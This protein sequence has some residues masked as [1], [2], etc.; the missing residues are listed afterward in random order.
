MTATQGSAPPAAPE[1]PALDALVRIPTLEP[2][3]A[4]PGALRPRSPEAIEREWYEKVYRGA[5][6]TL[7]QLTLRAVAMGAVL[8]GLMALTNLY[9]AL[10]VGFTS[11]VAITACIMSYAIWRSCR[12]SP[13]GA[14]GFSVGGTMASAIAAMLMITG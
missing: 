9:V 8:G 14:A 3:P 7:P 2:D 13:A 12:L 10:K 11:G 4:R 1:S 5:G 6:D